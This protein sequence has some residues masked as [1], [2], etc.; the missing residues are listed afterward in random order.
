MV[1]ALGHNGLME[2]AS[3][4]FRE[5]INLVIAINFDGFLGGV[6]YHMAFVAPMEVLIQLSPQA[7]AD[8]AV[9]IIGQLL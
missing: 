6:H 7:R 5:L 2:A 9:K 4:V 8:F 1:L 3:K